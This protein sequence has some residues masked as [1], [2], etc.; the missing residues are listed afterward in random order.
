MSTTYMFSSLLS[1]TMRVVLHHLVDE[2]DDGAVGVDHVELAGHGVRIE[3]GL[4][5][6]LGDGAGVD[7]AR[8]V[9]AGIVVAE[10]ARVRLGRRNQFQLA[11][12]EV[13]Q[14]QPVVDGNEQAAE[15]FAGDG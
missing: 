3:M 2:R 14:H 7:A 12:G 1:N 9:A 4:R 13:E 5:V 11:G 8:G 15:R 10:L 6:E